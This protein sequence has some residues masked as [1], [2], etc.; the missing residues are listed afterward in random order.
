MINIKRAKGFLEILFWTGL[1]RID[2]RIAQ[3]SDSLNRL[4][5]LINLMVAVSILSLSL[6]RSL[7]QSV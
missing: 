6:F 5:H 7:I 1:S 2:S 3:K 4:V